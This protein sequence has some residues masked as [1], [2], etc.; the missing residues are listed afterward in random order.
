M[1]ISGSLSRRGGAYVLVLVMAMILTTLGLSAHLIVQQRL[2]IQQLRSHASEADLIAM[3]AIDLAVHDGSSKTDWAASYSSA[4]ILPEIAIGGGTATVTYTDKS[5]D[6]RGPKTVRAI[7]KRSEAVRMLEV[8]V[9]PLYDPLPLLSYSI[10]AATDVGFDQ[11]DFYA[12]SSVHCNGDI[13]ASSSSITADVRANGSITGGTYNGSTNSSASSISLPT[14]ANL[15]FY[16]TAGVTIPISD[17]PSDTIE[18]V[19]L[20]PSS[21]PYGPTHPD[22]VYVIDC[23]GRSLDI[24]DARIVGT[25]VLHQAGSGTRIRDTVSLEKGAAG[26]PVLIVDG[27]LEILLAKEDLDESDHGVN[28]NPVG[29]P[30]NGVED[31]DQVDTYPTRISGLIYCNN[32]VSITAPLELAGLIVAR[33]VRCYDWTL[34]VHDRSYYDNPP[35]GFGTV[36]GYRIVGGTWRRAVNP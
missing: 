4:E 16:R 32:S 14:Y 6:P 34:I 15:S 11:A 31:S 2:K 30:S 8:D 17:I 23:A 27:P 20:S 10:A 28:F 26:Y 21:N 13:S 24:R 36:Q 5:A 7:A 1:T 12:D 25:L 35:P 3:S 29:S 22:G 18:R 33:Q 9:D 19:V